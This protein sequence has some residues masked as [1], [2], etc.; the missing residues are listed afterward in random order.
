MSL[1]ESETKMLFFSAFGFGAGIWL[2]IK[3]F[4]TY[5]RKKLIEDTPTSK[6]RS[7]AM[8]LVEVFGTAVPAEKI[9]MKSPLTGKECVYY[10]YEIQEYRST[11]KHSSW[12]TV[13]SGEKRP[14]FFLKDD[15][16]RVLVDPR[17]ANIDIPQDYNLESGIG[18]TP[19]ESI[20]KFLVAN[21]LSHEGFMGINR[22]M[23][24]IEYVLAVGDK[25]YILGTAGNNPFVEQGS[26]KKSENA[27]M[28]QKG[29]NEKEYYISDKPEKDV[30]KSLD[31]KTFGQIFG[32]IG[33]SAVCLAVFMLLLG[34]F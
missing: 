13:K 2:F 15:T 6:V 32:G 26:A 33:L 31:L 21:R 22:R 20:R 3:G 1:S 24:F 5:R 19:P 11:G 17:S 27:L 4:S 29:S 9:V 8:G 10:K 14:R 7:I 25:T 30:L 18:R 12:V 28:I 16:G 34:I 23:K